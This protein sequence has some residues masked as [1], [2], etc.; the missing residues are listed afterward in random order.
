VI[1][2]AGFFFEVEGFHRVGLGAIRQARQESRH[3]QAQVARVFGFAQR[4]PGGVLG[5]AEDLGQVARVGQFLPR[6]HL[7][8]GRAGRSHEGG[9][10]RRGDLGISPSISTSGG[11]WSK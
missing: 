8:H 5:R 10:R 4:T 11:V 7:H 1:A 3:G 6:A 9:V 2:A